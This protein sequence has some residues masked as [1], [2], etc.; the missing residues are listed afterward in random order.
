MPTAP[1]AGLQRSVIV[2]DDDVLLREGIA[3]LLGDAGYNV[4]ARAADGRELANSV[5]AAQPDLVVV[6]I[7]MP[8]THTSEG[9]DVAQAI[10]SE[11]PGS[12]CCCCQRMSRSIPPL[13]SSAA[14]TASAIC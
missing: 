6:D 10:R 4:I 8:P 9:I 2:A 12:G 5:R 3:R 14:E 13:T 1:A 7:R 11:F